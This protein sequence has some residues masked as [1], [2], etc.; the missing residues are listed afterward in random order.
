MADRTRR[1]RLI[2][3]LLQNGPVHNQEQLS[4]LLSQRGVEAAQATISRDLRDL[5]VLKGP[6][7]YRLPDPH[8]F[9]EAARGGLAEVL[10]SYVTRLDRGGSIVIVRTGPGHAQVVALELDRAG[11]PGTIGTVAGDDTIFM[12][13]RDDRAARAVLATLS[14]LS[15]LA[16][17]GAPQR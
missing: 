11:I 14:R 9:P 8:A 17:K 7:G 2:G 10:R 4:D 1:L 16:P 5:G 6:S 15:G 12:A 13:T 3:E